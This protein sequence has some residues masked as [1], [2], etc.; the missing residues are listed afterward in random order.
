MIG[1]V[2]GGWVTVSGRHAGSTGTH[3]LAVSRGRV[4][5][6]LFGGGGR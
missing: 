3:G 6:L 1:A 2:G 5:L 4:R